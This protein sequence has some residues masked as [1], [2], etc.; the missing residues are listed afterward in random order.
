MTRYR[1]TTNPP[2]DFDDLKAGKVALAFCSREH[3]DVRLLDTLD[4][5]RAWIAVDGIVLPKGALLTHITTQRR[6]D[7]ME[8]GVPDVEAHTSDRIGSKPINAVITVPQLMKL[9]AEGR[10]SLDCSSGRDPN[11]CLMRRKASGFSPEI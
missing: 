5:Q 3:P 2:S 7:P 11:L 6:E 10:A 9:V 8:T 1:L 4:Q